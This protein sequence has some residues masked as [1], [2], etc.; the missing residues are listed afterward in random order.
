MPASGKLNVCDDPVESMLNLTPEVPTTKVCAVLSRL[1][2]DMIPV[3]ARPETQF[4]PE[5]VELSAVRK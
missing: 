2:I 5:S 3:V 4:K 1:F